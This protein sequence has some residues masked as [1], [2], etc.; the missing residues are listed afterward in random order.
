[1]SACSAN[2]VIAFAFAIS[3]LLACLVSLYLVAQSGSV[4]YKMGVSMVLI[5][6]VSS[7]IGGMGS[8]AGAALGGFLVGI[9]SVSL[10]AYLPVDLRPYR[11]AFVFLL[12]IVFLFWRPDG[13]LMK[14]PTGSESEPCRIFPFAVPCRLPQLSLP[15]CWL[16]CLVATLAPPAMQR[17]VTEALI[18]LIV[19]VGLFIFVG[20]SGVFSFGHVA[21]MAIG[22]YISAILTLSPAR[23]DTLLDL[24]GWHRGDAL[25]L[26]SRL[27]DWCSLPSAC[28]RC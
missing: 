16:S 8:L 22:G 5:A 19:V 26:A 2:R 25:A 4:S 23:K 1:M 13:L 20:N 21:F 9:V 6:F 24:P 10:Q 3:G 27:A 14:R 7:V 11:D 28:W 15:S 18:K 12:F 17:T